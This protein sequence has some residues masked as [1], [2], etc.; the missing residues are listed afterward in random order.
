MTARKISRSHEENHWILSGRIQ[1]VG[2]RARVVSI[3]KEFGVVGSVQNLADGRVRII[4]EC[5]EEV[6]ERFLDAIRIKNTLINV[7]N[8]LVEYSDATGDYAAFYK[9]VG[10]GETGKRLDKASE[11]LKDM[12]V[13]MKTGFGDMRTGFKDMQT[14]FGEMKEEMKTGFEMLG[15][16]EDRTIEEIGYVRGDLNSYLCG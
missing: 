6:S 15:S 5:E 13:I 12:I 9:L 14:G 3:A 8:V 1:N 11:Y 4:A 16:K 2:Y 10:E 7:H